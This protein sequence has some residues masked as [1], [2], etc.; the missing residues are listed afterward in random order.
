MRD[1]MS[2]SKPSEN[3]GLLIEWGRYAPMPLVL[4]FKTPCNHYGFCVAE[5]LRTIPFMGATY[6]FNLTGGATMTKRIM[7][8]L[9]LCFFFSISAM[10]ATSDAATVFGGSKIMSV[11]QAQRTITFKTKEGQTWTLPVADPNVLNRQI[12]K[13]DDV[14]IELDLNDRITKVIKLSGGAPTSPVQQDER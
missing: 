6:A 5:P 11:D 3:I 9:T 4:I 7:I 8:I 1:R 13:G 12:A 2:G 10:V 14:T